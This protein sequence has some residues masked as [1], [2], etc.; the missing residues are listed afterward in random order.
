[1]K[2]SIIILGS[3]GSIGKSTVSIIKKNK[4]HFNVL[5]LTC[6]NNYYEIIKQA[7]LLNPKNLIVQDKVT[8]LRVKKKLIKTKIKIFNNLNLIQKIIKK[9][10]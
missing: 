7:K 3:T 5:L 4:D 2:K 8:F 10:S 1:M 6:N 9:K